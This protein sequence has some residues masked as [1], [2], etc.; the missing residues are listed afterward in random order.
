M[1]KLF[2]E[3]L[4]FIRS[5][6]PLL[7][8]L[9]ALT[10]FFALLS[11]SIRKKSTVYYL[12]FAIPFVLIL[13]PFLAKLVGVQLDGFVR[14]PFLGEILRDYIH[15]GSFGHPLL[16][17]IMYIGALDMKTPGVKRL[18]SIRKEMSIISGFAV[19]SHSL[20]R[21][22]NNLP[23]AIRFFADNA[24]YMADV[25]VVS[26]TGAGITSFSYIVG[27]LLLVLFIPLWVTSFDSV[28]NR[29]TYKKWKKIQRLAYVMYTAL[30]IHAMGILIGGMLNPRGGHAQKP[31][32][33]KVVAQAPDQQQKPVSVEVKPN[34]G[35]QNSADA[36]APRVGEGHGHR[37][38]LKPA[39]ADKQ[40][41]STVKPTN[42][43]AP[44]KGF[45]DIQVSSR[46]KQFIHLFSLL[47][48]YG[49]YLYLRLRKA[50]RDKQKSAARSH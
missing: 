24:G 47:L 9:A 15:M 2:I 39:G 48:I 35:N 22:I 29:M 26:E 3:L 12:V 7:T 49:S 19:L 30:F 16:I 20:I 44:S 11:K 5:C 31:A 41:Q 14:V 46:T 40:P 50:K 8:S 34:G 21:V 36:P 27:V 13:L 37:A 43:R 17:I 33:E 18:M 23:P 25:K 6:A 32:V 45:A 4:E 42:R 28:R 38:D 10:L 1:V